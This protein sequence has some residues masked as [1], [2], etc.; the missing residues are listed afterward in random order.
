MLK[1]RKYQEEAVKKAIDFFNSNSEEPALIVLPTGWGKSILTAFAAAHIPQYERLLV[2]QPSKELLEQNY[3]KYMLLCGEE[4]KAGIYS[5]SFGKKQVERITYATIGSIKNIGSTF[6]ELGFT[7]MLIDEAHL[8]PRKEKSMLGQFLKDSG[9]KQVLGLTATPLKLEQF[10]EKHNER[11]DKWSEIIML[12][13]TSPSGKFFKSIIHIGQIN[14]MTSLKFWSPLKYDMIPFDTRML[15]INTSGTDF[16]DQSIR[17]SYEYNNI[18]QN[19][20]ACLAY[21]RK[22][23]HCLVYVPSVEEAKLLSED[24]EKAA[25]ISGDMGKKERNIVINAFRNGEIR[26][27]FNVGVLACG[28]DYPQT[29]LIILGFATNSVAK[30]YQIVGRGVRIHP[31]KENCIIIDM[32][33]NVTRFGKVEDITFSF[34][35]GKWNMY[36]TN[37]RLLSGIPIQCIGLLYKGDSRPFG[38][39]VFPGGK[40]AGTPIENVPLSYIMWCI[41]SGYQSKIHPYLKYRL[42]NHFNDTTSLPPAE[43][44][45]DGKY[46][47]TP[48]AQVPKGYLCWYYGSKEWNETNDDLKR[49]IVNTLGFEPRPKIQ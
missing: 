10:G 18:R 24:C 9:I 12:T 45:P 19:I 30:Y 22:R 15:K 37:N 11:F 1:L 8:Y 16:S 14:E 7:K 35:N 21:Y 40:Y 47:G 39:V 44:M 25:Y 28:F 33:G 48:I 49:G 20:F 5:A 31:D 32:G 34:E 2:V 29:D 36:G 17:E 6:K 46:S 42:E 38:D 13:N 4:A 3:N 43:L 26:V 27:L 41:Q 23:K